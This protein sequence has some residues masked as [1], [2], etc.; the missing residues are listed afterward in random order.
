MQPLMGQMGG[1]YYL[2][3]QGHGVY[4][5]KPY[6]NQPYQGAWNQMPK[7]RIPFL[8]M[9]NLPD[10]LILTNDLVSHNLTWS[11]VP[12]KIPLDIPKIEDKTGEDLGEHV[13]TF[14]LWCSSNSLN[15][16]L[17]HLRLFQHILTGPMAKWYIELPQGT[18]TSFNDLAMTFLNHF[19]LPVHYEQRCRY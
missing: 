11:V 15:H 3:V 6:V 8:V 17:V 4:N 14:H 18:Y 10:L 2:T 5:N 16:D 7:S 9:L 13:M 19:Q 1:G 12:A